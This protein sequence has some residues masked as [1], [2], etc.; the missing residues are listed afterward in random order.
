[1][2]HGRSSR[3]AAVSARRHHGYVPEPDEEAT[4]LMLEALF[5]I[6]AAVFEIHRALFGED[7]EGQET[8]ED[9]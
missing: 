6:K 3:L 9:A 4:Q 5:D 2:R 1:M 8:E 7:D